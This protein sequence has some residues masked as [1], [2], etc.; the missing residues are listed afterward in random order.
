[1]TNATTNDTVALLGLKA[2]PLTLTATEHAGVVSATAS[3]TILVGPLDHIDVSPS[4]TSLKSGAS[5]TFS[6]VGYDLNNN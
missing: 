5:T 1:M 6:A 4:F 3:V 2:G